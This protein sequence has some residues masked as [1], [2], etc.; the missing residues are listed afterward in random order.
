MTNEQKQKIEN[1]RR[2]GCGYKRISV[3]MEMPL[4]TIKSYCRRNEA[5]SDVNRC[6]NCGKP[7]EHSETG[8]P[9]KYC[10]PRCR[11]EYVR[12]H[13][14]QMKTKRIRTHI[15]QCCGRR[16]NSYRDYSKFCSTECYMDYRFGG[17]RYY[18]QNSSEKS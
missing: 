12:K 10:C 11:D 17:V 7:L 15:C 3:E 9:K 16:F 2:E 13:I 4:S 14:D 18:D 5:S 6:P 1:R 8:R